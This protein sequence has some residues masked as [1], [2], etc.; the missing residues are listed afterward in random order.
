M[1]KRGALCLEWSA[2][3]RLSLGL[4]LRSG[5]AG[6]G[7]L[8]LGVSACLMLHFDLAARTLSESLLLSYGRSINFTIVFLGLF[9]RSSHYF[10]LNTIV[11]VIFMR[12]IFS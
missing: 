4:Q 12:L 5:L 1:K 9:E 3:R 8:A 6:F 11:L 7:L 2:R 10:P